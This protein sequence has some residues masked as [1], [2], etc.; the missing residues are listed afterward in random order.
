MPE[1]P[2]AA[3]DAAPADAVIPV[4]VLDTPPVPSG[5]AGDGATVPG[6]PATVQ[7]DLPE[8]LHDDLDDPVHHPGER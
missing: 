1:E 6:A 4:E 7:S 2:V 3:L 5:R 8:A